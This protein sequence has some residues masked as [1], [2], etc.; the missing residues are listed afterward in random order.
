VSIECIFSKCDDFEREWRRGVLE[1][2]KGYGPEDGFEG[3]GVLPRYLEGVSLHR[4]LFLQP[5][6][7]VCVGGSDQQVG[8][9]SNIF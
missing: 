6:P 1:V 9:I 5:C 4:K 3:V 7:L 8:H 2:F